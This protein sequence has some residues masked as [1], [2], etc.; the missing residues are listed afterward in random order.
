M[1]I[2]MFSAL[3]SDSEAGE[4]DRRESG[5][6]K[7]ALTLSHAMAAFIVT[8]APWRTSHWNPPQEILNSGTQYLIAC[9]LSA[10]GARLPARQGP[11][12]LLFEAFDKFDIAQR[13]SGPFAA[14][15]R[16]DRFRWLS[17]R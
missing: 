5:D 8:G 4:V 10:F 1:C 2:A 9:I 15:D 3:A 7:G 12:K 13:T 14:A 6:P 16:F 17:A 11:P